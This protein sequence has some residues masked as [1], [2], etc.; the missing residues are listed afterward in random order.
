VPSWPIT[1][2]SKAG[3]DGGMIKI[4]PSSAM[5][6][7]SSPEQQPRM[8]QM[9]ISSEVSSYHGNAASMFRDDS[10]A[11]PGLRDSPDMPDNKDFPTT[12]YVSHLRNDNSVAPYFPL[13]PPGSITPF[14][15]SDSGTYVMATTSLAYRP[16]PCAS[17][18]GMTPPPLPLTSHF[19]VG[20]NL[21]QTDLEGTFS[22]T[23][24]LGHSDDALPYVWQNGSE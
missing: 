16:M 11:T 9:V 7:I 21:Q 17:T 24:A 14:I 4:E 23:T 22:Q 8:T 1:T 2:S 15:P 18:G 13:P 5:Q 20:G 3:S 19:S 6:L 10:L 12:H